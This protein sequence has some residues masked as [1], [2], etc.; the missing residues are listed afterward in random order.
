MALIGAVIGVNETHN[1]FQQ[2]LERTTVNYRT[3]VAQKLAN[4]KYI[5]KN[6]NSKFSQTETELF[7]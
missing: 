6:V 7:R 1:Q 2:N 3:E 5:F 4:N